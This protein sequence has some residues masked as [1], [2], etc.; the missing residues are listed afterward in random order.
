M[1]D[2]MIAV[3]T[4]RIESLERER[5]ELENIT[6]TLRAMIL[7][8]VEEHDQQGKGMDALMGKARRMILK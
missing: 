8:L 5:K 7:L 4:R 6:A 2:T 3:W 1:N